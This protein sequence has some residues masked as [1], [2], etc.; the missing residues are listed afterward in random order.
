MANL[1]F[2]ACELD[3]EELGQWKF[4]ADV[5][6]EERKC[7]DKQRICLEHIVRLQ[8]EDLDR[9]I[10]LVDLLTTNGEHQVAVGHLCVLA[11]L[12]P[13]TYWTLIALADCCFACDQSA[14]AVTYLEQQLLDLS[15]PITGEF[16]TAYVKVLKD[17]LDSAQSEALHLCQ[18]GGK[19]IA[20][21]DFASAQLFYQKAHDKDANCIQ[22]TVG[23]VQCSKNQ[24]GDE[25]SMSMSEEEEWK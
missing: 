25:E 12:C 2:R 7:F 16:V 17:C 8:R 18:Q 14:M 10:A 5:F 15:H 20:E 23:L 11:E 22:A 19:L 3:P 21:S 6:A 4:V 13:G 9:R 24:E 1:C